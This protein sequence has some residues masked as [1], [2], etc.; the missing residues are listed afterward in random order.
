MLSQ[1][2]RDTTLLRGQLPKLPMASSNVP[3]GALFCEPVRIHK[4]AVRLKN[5]EIFEKYRQ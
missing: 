2:R 1:A 3:D 5:S 4:V